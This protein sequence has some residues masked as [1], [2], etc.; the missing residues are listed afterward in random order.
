MRIIIL[1]TNFLIYCARFRIDFISEIERICFFKYKLAI[2]D[3]TIEELERVKPKE[4]KLVKK[5]I[6]NLEVI[7]SEGSYV[8]ESLIELSK[9]GYVVATQDKELKDKLEGEVIIIRK[10]KYLELK[11]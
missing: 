3:Q 11:E 1:D 2:L 10:Q 6:E 8:D 7:K 4:L 9:K 5:F